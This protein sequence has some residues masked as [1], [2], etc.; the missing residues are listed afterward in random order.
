MT[1]RRLTRTAALVALAVGL[2]LAP[3][4]GP[5]DVAGAAPASGVT[6]PAVP[7]GEVTAPAVPTGG[8]LPTAIAGDFEAGNIISDPVFFDPGTMT[9]D[10]VQAFLNAR[11]ANCVPGEQPCLKDY[12]T[13]TVAK[14][15]D[16][17]CNGYVGGRTESAAQII[18]G[19]ANS[20]GVNPRALLV[21]LEKEQSLITRTKP[22]TYAYERATGFGCPDT[23]PC[24]AEYFGLFNQVYLAARQ[25]QRY[26]LHPE[27]YP[28]Y[29][30]GRANT[31][32]YHPNAA[33]GT[34]SVYIENQATAGL[35][36]YTPY[37]PNAA[38]LANLYG[39][40]D[41][42]SSY[43]NRN[44]WR[45]FT[46]WFGSTQGGGFLVRT[47]DNPTVYL[48]SGTMKH[49]VP[50]EALLA[51]YAPLGPVGYVSDAYLSR[52]TTGRTVDRWVR[53]PEG[54]I[55]YVDSGTRYYAGTCSLVADF[56][57]E[58]STWTQLT[59]AHIAMLTPG[60]NLQQ[61]VR[62]SSGR[63]YYVDDRVRREVADAASLTANGLPTA[64]VSMA[65]A[66]VSWLPVGDPVV[67]NGLVVTNR[68]TGD[69]SLFSSTGMN[70]LPAALASGTALRLL[71]QGALDGSSMA[72]VAPGPTMSPFVRTADGAF[73]LRGSSIT[74]LGDASLAPS[75]T[76]VVGAESLAGFT[77]T[78][79][80]SAPLFIQ[81][82]GDALRYEI[83]AGVRH[84]VRSDAELT[85]LSGTAASVLAVTPQVA[86]LVPIGRDAALTRFDDVRFTHPFARDIVWLAD[87]GVT[88][89]YADGTF[90][91]SAPVN[92]DAMAAFLYRASGS[93]AFT[94]PATP[95]FTDVPAGHPF[96]KEIE[97]LASRGITTGTVQADG[98]R[99]Y[100][101]AA[102]VSREA[103][104]AFLYRLAGSPAFT[105]P[106]T[107][108]FVDVSTGNPFFTAVEWLAERGVTTGTTQA[109]GTVRF[110]P[111]SAVS[112]EAMAAFL[113]RFGAL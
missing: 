72:R 16:E 34:S 73:L 53:S 55:Y 44:F 84:P 83:R 105:P 46:D 12:R 62:T 89:G 25:Y 9:A 107:P 91:P 19:V 47:V 79:A 54:A 45:L 90:R 67:R 3:P 77:P 82:V 97:W 65:G 40:G 75:V 2:T 81:P 96:F 31:I 93:P 78:G 18:V 101:P 70:P 86:G 4:P 102:P 71:P 17:M 74:R 69:L 35:Y 51:T 110:E 92:R 32:Q 85:V 1:H 20:C 41:S 63:T 56:G 57:G 50:S 95:T 99:G 61:V 36:T 113:H 66:A 11:G 59:D 38:A 98:T 103:M 94:P 13:T 29:R 49:P 21:L 111:S 33:C 100:S 7:S 26:A 14:A 108:R 10:Q 80:V 28:R 42:C 60:S 6:A 8:L 22:T 5:A 24:N 43:G 109:D 104:A 27:Q 106:A 39:L 30:P 48:I 52:R 37:R 15:A 112:R 88:T 87:T 64:S 58:C 68:A 76:A 23:A